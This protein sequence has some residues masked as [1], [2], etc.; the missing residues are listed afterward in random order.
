MVTGGEGFHKALYIGLTDVGD[1]VPHART[2]LNQGLA[3]LQR[4]DAQV[5]TDP[6]T[7]SRQAWAF[8]M[9]SPA[10]GGLKVA[11]SLGVSMKSRDCTIPDLSRL[12]DPMK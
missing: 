10:D 4:S 1:N 5:S 12:P 6:E 7:V 2:S 3:S 8:R 9:V 11:R